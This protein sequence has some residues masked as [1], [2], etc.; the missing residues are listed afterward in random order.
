MAL[1]RVLRIGLTALAAVASAEEA[2]ASEE[3]EEMVAL[4]TRPAANKS[5]MLPPARCGYA[6]FI[7]STCDKGETSYASLAEA[8]AACWASDKCAG[9]LDGSKDAALERKFWTC[10]RQRPH[11]SKTESSVFL[12]MGDEECPAALSQQEPLR[13]AMV[14]T[15][16]FPPNPTPAEP[17]IIGFPAPLPNYPDWIT[18]PQ[19]FC[20]YPDTGA[21]GYYTSADA[22]AS[23]CAADTACA[24]IYNSQGPGTSYPAQYWYKCKAPNSNFRCGSWYQGGYQ[25]VVYWKDPNPYNNDCQR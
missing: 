7:Q 10:K 2:C 24:G 3:A 13:I 8:K 20:Y 12:L 18:M 9:F 21:G 23:G 4:Q 14:T 11:A 5:L 1:Q 17:G 22:A 15:E 16:Q 6:Q 25:G 19:T